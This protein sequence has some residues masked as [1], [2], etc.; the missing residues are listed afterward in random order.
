VRCDICQID[1][2]NL[3]ASEY[4]KVYGGMG[5]ANRMV[6]RACMSQVSRAAVA[7]ARLG[8]TAMEAHISGTG[9]VQTEVSG[10]GVVE[11]SR[12][13]LIADLVELR[14]ELG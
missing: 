1:G 4:G 8:P 5:R 6:C 12:D 9:T 11:Q 2:R 13:A 10:V 3:A 14:E 7:E